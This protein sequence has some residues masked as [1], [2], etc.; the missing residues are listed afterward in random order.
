MQTNFHC[1]RRT[2]VPHEA[3]KYVYTPESLVM[4]LRVG[5]F[6][7]MWNCPLAISVVRPAQPAGLQPEDSPSGP[8]QDSERRGPVTVERHAI[9]DVTRIGLWI[10]GTITMLSLLAA[11]AGPLFLRTRRKNI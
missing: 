4:V 11:V 10:M 9:V 1:G 3:G 8:Q 6:G 2:G 5:G 7:A